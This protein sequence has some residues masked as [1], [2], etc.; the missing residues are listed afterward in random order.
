M[1]GGELLVSA[2]THALKGHID[3]EKGRM[4]INGIAAQITPAN[5]AKRSSFIKAKQARAHSIYNFIAALQ[6]HT[7][8]VNHQQQ[9]AIVLYIQIPQGVVFD[10][11]NGNFAAD[12]VF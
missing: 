11:P 1:N 4:K 3:V 2:R 6:A 10:A 8:L 9:K 7:S 5:Q 12:I